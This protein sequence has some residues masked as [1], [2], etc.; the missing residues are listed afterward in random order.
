MLARQ[1]ELF[2]HLPKAPV[3]VRA[4]EA[5]REKSA[6]TAHYRNPPQD[7]SAPGIFYIHLPEMNAQPRYQLPATPYHEAITRHHTETHIPPEMEGLPQFPRT[8]HLLSFH[9]DR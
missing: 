8:P 1:G 6:P 7:G 9:K 2:A 5:W 4:I 3:E